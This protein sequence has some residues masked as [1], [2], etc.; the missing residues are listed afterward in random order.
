[1]N[2][3]F[4]NHLYYEDDLVNEE[5]QRNLINGYKKAIKVDFGIDLI[6]EKMILPI[7][8]LLVTQPFLEK[9]KY[10]L[11]IKRIRQGEMEISIPVEEFFD[12]DRARVIIDGH[13][14]ARARFD[15]RYKDIKC[16]L[17]Y[18][19]VSYDSN[20]LKLARSLGFKRIDQIPLRYSK[21][22]LINK[23]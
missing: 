22:K 13:V 16:L 7:R 8:S 18:S 23:K 1:M 9:E 19:F 20:M 12:E 11:V 15:L 4:Y 5:K 6:E 14:R 10:D 21:D 3:D 17:L 2:R